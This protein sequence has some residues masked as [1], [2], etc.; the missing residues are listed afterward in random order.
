MRGGFLAIPSCQS[1][2]S[3]AFVTSVTHDN[4]PPAPVNVQPAR[5]ENSALRKRPR[6][7]DIDPKTA[8][9]NHSHSGL[10]PRTLRSR[11]KHWRKCIGGRVVWYRF[12]RP[13][14]EGLT[15]LAT[16]TPIVPIRREAATS[17]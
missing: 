4:R 14:R 10:P 3:C 7:L 8:L 2:S 5:P 9:I 12:V 15:T 6:S 11:K 17:E 16:L 13:L 1:H